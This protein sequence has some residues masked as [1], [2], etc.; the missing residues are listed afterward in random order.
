ME[1]EELHEKLRTHPFE[2]FRIYV[3]D[4][5]HY[6][7]K[8]PEQIMISKRVSYVGISKNGDGPFQKIASISNVHI[9][10]VETING[11]TATRKKPRK[12]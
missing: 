9:T 11:K 4:G 5:H 12:K 3:T 10:R 2:S 7:I 6:D 8:H 1:A